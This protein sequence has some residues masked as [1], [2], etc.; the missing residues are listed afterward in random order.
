MNWLRN[1]LIVGILVIV[2]VLFIRWNGFQEQKLE[3]AQA[4]E[5]PLQT[6]QPVLDDSIPSQAV[7]SAPAN[8]NNTDI[9]SLTPSAPTDSRAV[10]QNRIHVTT[11]TLDILI[12]PVGGDITQVMLLKHKADKPN[13]DQPFTM[14]KQSNL[15][16][17]IAKSGMIGA[18]G[19]DDPSK[20]R[21]VYRAA[22][23]RYTLNDTAETLEVDLVLEQEN[24]T[25]T[26]R[27][28]FTKGAYLIDVKYIIAN[29]AATPWNATL[30]GQIIRDGSK[31]STEYLG[32]Q[33][34]LGAAITQTET[35]YKK[36]SFGDIDDEK[37]AYAKQG[38]WI[39]LIQHYYLSAWIPPAE[40]NN[41]YELT[42]SSRGNYVMRFISEPT[43][44]ES[45]QTGEV[46]ARF[47]VGP[48]IINT[49]EKISPNLELT[50]DYGWLWFIGKPLFSLMDMLHDLVGNW[51]VAI[52]MLTMIIKA[53]FLW[54]S[55][56]SYRSMAKMRKLQPMMADLKERYGEDRQRMSQ[57]LMKL[58]RKEKVNPLG[59]CLPI[60]LQMPV[61]IALYYVIMESVQLRH[62]PFIFWIQD[63]SVKDPLFILPLLMGVTMWVQQ[64]LN[65]TPPDPMQAK[66]MKMLPIFFTL[67]FMFFPAGLVLYW[68]VNNTLSIIQQYIITKQIEKAD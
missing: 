46:S 22:S 47:Y 52:I 56:M 11:D 24:A 10:S 58:Y 23:S 41:Q 44:V 36:I 63:L 53:V 1:A 20:G 32:M 29:R 2:Y 7:P 55:A 40:A 28:I 19:T 8:A 67:L 49:L 38:G 35:N 31:P 15:H 6:A 64:Q 65:P 3:L 34:F 33:P 42:K 12:D 48:K 45:R 61:F 51:G 18:N 57:E 39:A 16:T 9:P 43:I 30:Y 50:V 5:T 21:G 68:V 4:N 60:L 37:I 59:G 66:I 26:K 62:E 27:F 14:L 25:V 54:P 17:Y 13:K